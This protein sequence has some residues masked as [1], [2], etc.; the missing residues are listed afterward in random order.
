MMPLI[1]G[2]FLHGDHLSPLVEFGTE[3]WIHHP[4]SRCQKIKKVDYE[5]SSL[6]SIWAIQDVA[7]F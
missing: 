4:I 7:M 2:S 5:P 3:G 1:H 6:K